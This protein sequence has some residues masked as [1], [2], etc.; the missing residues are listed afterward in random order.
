MCAQQTEAREAALV[1]IAS[2]LNLNGSALNI[3]DKEVASTAQS[4]V[5][6]TGAPTVR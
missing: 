5:A 3:S 1:L 2:V 4:L 6:V